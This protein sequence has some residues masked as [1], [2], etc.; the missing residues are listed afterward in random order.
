MFCFFFATVTL[1]NVAH[2]CSHFS[3]S[4]YIYKN[5]PQFLKAMEN[6]LFSKEKAL[7]IL[8]K[9]Q[10]GL[11]FLNWSLGIGPDSQVITQSVCICSS[12]LKWLHTEAPHIHSNQNCICTISRNE[13]PSLLKN[14]SF[15]YTFVSTYASNKV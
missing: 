15:F 1:S 4:S 9:I 3:R 14:N 7:A 10:V 11:C 6:E 13:A 8:P 5:I 2:K 12:F